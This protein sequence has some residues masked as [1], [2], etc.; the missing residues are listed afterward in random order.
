VDVVMA[1]LHE[2]VC[3]LAYSTSEKYLENFDEI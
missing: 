3:P 2:R 1:S